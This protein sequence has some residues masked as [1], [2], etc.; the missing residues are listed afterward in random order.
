VVLLLGGSS[1]SFCT[2]CR[3]K[4]VPVPDT[5]ADEADGDPA[6]QH[7]ALDAFTLVQSDGTYRAL[8]FKLPKANDED[9]DYRLVVYRKQGG[10]YVRRGTEFNLVNFERPRLSSGSPPRIETTERRLGVRYH[11]VIGESG[12]EMAPSEVLEGGALLG[13][14]T[15]G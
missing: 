3:Q 14:P 13:H 6:T 12:P 4:E 5:V 2:A 15:G 9:S 1:A 11:F 7:H 10:V 8:V